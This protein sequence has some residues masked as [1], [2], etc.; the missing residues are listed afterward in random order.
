MSR[1]SEQATCLDGAFV[2]ARAPGV[3][4]VDADGEAILFDPATDRLHLLNPA[5]ALLWGLFDGHAPLATI[6]ADI[7][8]ELQV[9]LGQVLTDSLTAVEGLHE[10]GLVHDGRGVPPA[11]APRAPTGDDTADEPPGRLLAEPPDT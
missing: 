11:S 10:L 6:C 1:G 9:P 2:P 3:V 4:T 5:A 7:A 8:A